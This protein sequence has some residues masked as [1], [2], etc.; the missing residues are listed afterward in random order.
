MSLE[1][2]VGAK[3]WRDI[4]SAVMENQPVLYTKIGV[5]THNRS[6]PNRVFC[7]RG[8]ELLEEVSVVNGHGGEGRG[9]ERRRS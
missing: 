6:L 4:E 1:E 9:D 2:D 7:I 3:R 5:S 8:L